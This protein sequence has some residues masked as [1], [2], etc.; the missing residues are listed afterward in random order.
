MTFFGPF[1]PS[2][3]ERRLWLSYAVLAGFGAMLALSTLGRFSRMA[4][5]SLQGPASGWVAI[6]GAVGLPL[7]VYLLRGWIG[8]GLLR[9]AAGFALVTLLAGVIGGTLALPIHG[10]MF[11]SWL[12]VMTLVS[13]P[14]LSVLWLATYAAVHAAFRRWRIERDTIFADPQ[15]VVLS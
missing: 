14:I 5:W 8:F 13:A 15:A 7:S 12:I 10:T 2:P 9:A 1:K 4:D 11:G 6:C 3:G